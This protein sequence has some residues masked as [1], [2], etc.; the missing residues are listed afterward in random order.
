MNDFNNVKT[1]LNGNTKHEAEIWFIECLINVTPGQ[2]SV[3]MYNAAISKS[4]K[5][6]GK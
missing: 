2:I 4:A 6:L 3:K 5:L 1:F